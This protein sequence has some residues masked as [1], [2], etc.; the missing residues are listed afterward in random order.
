MLWIFAADR[1]SLISSL[2]ARCSSV[3]FLRL[4][5]IIKTSKVVSLLL[6]TTSEVYTNFRIDSPSSIPDSFSK[7][8]ILFI[9]LN[10]GV[11]FSLGRLHAKNELAKAS[12]IQKTFFS[13]LHLSPQFLSDIIIFPEPFNYSRINQL[14]FADFSGIHQPPTLTSKASVKAC[15]H[16]K[17]IK[18]HSEHDNRKKNDIKFIIMGRNLSKALQPE[19][20]TFYLITLFV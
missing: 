13:I 4:L 16:K 1:K 11:H 15:S 20:V 9:C 14:Q 8:L 18:N 3:S 19:K 5:L 2:L 10:F 6:Y 12:L 17:S 7:Y